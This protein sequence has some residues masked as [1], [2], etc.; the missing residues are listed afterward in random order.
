MIRNPIDI[1]TRVSPELSLL[2]ED[3]IHR[4]DSEEPV[5]LGAIRDFIAHELP[6]EIS[7]DEHLHHFDNA[8]SLVDELE[9][10]IEGFGE[11]A[12]AED[13]I[14]FQ[15]GEAL[16]RA[17]ESV[18]YDENRENAATLE[19]VRDALAEGLASRLVGDGVLEDD[20][21]EMLL[22]ELEALIARYGSDA[23]AEDFLRYE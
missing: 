10:L 3:I 9:A 2:I 17:M 4:L 13:F 11:S 8:E 20:E 12:V 6:A 7:E 15:A 16:S 21:A 18:I 5:T 22:P 23:L 1:A 19:S 14:A